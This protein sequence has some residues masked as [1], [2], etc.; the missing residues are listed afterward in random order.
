MSTYEKSATATNQNKESLIKSIYTLRVLTACK[1]NYRRCYQ[2]RHE[3]FQSFSN[4]DP[5][6]TFLLI[7]GVFKGYLLSS[8]QK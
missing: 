3:L 5:H 7:I 8:S 6:K 4:L 2:Q 1:C